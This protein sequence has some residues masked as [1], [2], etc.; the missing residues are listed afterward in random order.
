MDELD[1]R[2]ALAQ[3]HVKRGREIVERQR[4]IV[5]G[6][7]ALFDSKNLLATMERTLK[8]FEDDLERL[9]KEKAARA[10][11]RSGSWRCDQD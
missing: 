10:A 8:L 3:R 7:Y 4:R 2:I 9:L 6:G 11:E 1:Q 5:A